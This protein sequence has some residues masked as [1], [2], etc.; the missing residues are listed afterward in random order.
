MRPSRSS[1]STSCISSRPVQAWA[2]ACRSA[3]GAAEGLHRTRGPQLEELAEAVFDGTPSTS[4]RHH[5][6]RR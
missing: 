3:G 2:V 6:D 5:P 1:V 4:V